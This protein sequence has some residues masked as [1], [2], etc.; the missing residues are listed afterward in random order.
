MDN[1]EYEVE[2]GNRKNVYILI[3]DG[4]ILIRVPKRF[5]EYKIRNIIK[6]KEKWI[7][8]KLNEYKTFKRQETHYKEGE[9]FYILGNEYLLSFYETDKKRAYVEI[10]NEKICLYIPKGIELDEKQIKTILEKFYLKLAKLEIPEILDLVTKRVGL[11][12]KSFA[13]KNMKRAWGNCNS[14]KEIH[15]NKN[16]VK[17]SKKAIYYVCL[18]EVCHLKYM[19]H[20]KEFWKMVSNYM[21]DYK[22]VQKE[23]K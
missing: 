2:R 15:L 10:K 5:P 7:L 3:R 12:P 23:L 13:I 21:P 6:E 17:Y 14:K 22:L 11:F 8:E 9:K 1:I 19:N 4:K 18:H 20:S 16:L